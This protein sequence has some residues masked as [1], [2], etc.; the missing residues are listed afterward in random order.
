ML[1]LEFQISQ[2][3]TP[4]MSVLAD[5]FSKSETSLIA[6]NNAYHLWISGLSVASTV[7]ENVFVLLIIL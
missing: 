7:E 1:Y 2:R 5:L 4:K 3:T 6:S